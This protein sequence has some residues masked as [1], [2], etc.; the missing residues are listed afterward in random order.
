MAHEPHTPLVPFHQANPD[1]RSAYLRGLQ[2]LRGLDGNPEAWHCT[3]CG[4]TTPGD[5]VL[6]SYDI[7][8][9]PIPHCPAQGCTA[10]G[11]KLKPV[12]T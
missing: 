4:E 9:T 7:G 6:I 5:D 2:T 3:G 11:P 10:Y 12:T 1:T 8:D